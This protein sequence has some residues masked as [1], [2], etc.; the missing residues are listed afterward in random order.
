MVSLTIVDRLAGDSLSSCLKP[1]K[2]ILPTSTS[3]SWQV[4]PHVGSL[5]VLIVPSSLEPSNCGDGK[6][7]QMAKRTEKTI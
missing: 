6:M 7:D 5:R 1:G 4:P 2:L 3:V